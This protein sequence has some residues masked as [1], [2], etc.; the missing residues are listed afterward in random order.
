MLASSGSPADPITGVDAGRT[1]ESRGS[2]MSWG[3]ILGGAIA[4]L[5]LTVVLVAAMTGLGLTMISPWPNS[6]AS[7]VTFT[8]AAGIGL[9]VIQWLT[10]AFGGYVTGRLRAKWVAVHTHEVFFRD[11]AHGFLS[12]ATASVIGAAL[13]GSISAAAIG[14]GTRAAATVAAGAAQGG[15]VAASQMLP[16]QQ[17]GLDTL[18]RGTKPD[19]AASSADTRAETGRILAHGLLETEFPAADKT[20]L[21]GMIATRTGI[22]PAEAQKRIDDLV[23]QAK[24]AEVKARE[25]A[26]KARK[27]AAAAAIFTAIAMLIG[28][29]IASVT[30][31]FGG[32]QRDEAAE[33]DDHR[34]TRRA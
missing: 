33:Q 25:V 8:V 9:I 17:Y 2:A 27:S 28:A 12:W 23:A 4:T 18:F 31:A 21:A 24:A 3:A 30:A 32:H 13:V 5:A 22:P 15:A 20:Y 14:T 34:N 1:Y 7:P 29:F 19:M 6:G 11:S 10:A 26:D 16:S